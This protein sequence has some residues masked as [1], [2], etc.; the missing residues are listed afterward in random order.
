M[1]TVIAIY[2][3]FLFVAYPAW[4]GMALAG[5]LDRHIRVFSKHLSMLFH[6][7]WHWL[8][9]CVNTCCVSVRLIDL[10]HFHMR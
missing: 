3:D 2:L 9:D 1:N 7:E 4:L 5:D 8:V 6:R 10:H